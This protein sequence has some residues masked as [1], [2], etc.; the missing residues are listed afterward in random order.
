MLAK[1]TSSVEERELLLRTF[2]LIPTLRVEMAGGKF[3]PLSLSPALL[4]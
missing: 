4:L 1:G 3:E 2:A